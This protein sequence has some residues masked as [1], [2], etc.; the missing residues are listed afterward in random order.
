MSQP[1]MPQ[2]AMQK[3]QAN[4]KLPSKSLILIGSRQGTDGKSISSLASVRG[5]SSSCSVTADTPP[6]TMFC[7]RQVTRRWIVGDTAVTRQTPAR[8]ARGICRIDSRLCGDA[9][10]C[11]DGI[12]QELAAGISPYRHWRG[13][14]RVKRAMSI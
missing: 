1:L 11:D 10:G 8:A 4:P 3:R 5:R 9:R 14:W 12:R 13:R 2:R 7:S 6:S